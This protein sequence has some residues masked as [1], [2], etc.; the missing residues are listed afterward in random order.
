MLALKGGGREGEEQAAP[1]LPARPLAVHPHPG[2]ASQRAVHAQ[3]GTL[4]QL[5]AAE[6]Q[7]NRDRHGLNQAGRQKL[8]SVRQAG[9][10]GNI[11]AAPPTA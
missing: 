2:Q 3:C 10:N 11:E 6:E 5:T 4:S 7:S 8:H 1:L 9:T